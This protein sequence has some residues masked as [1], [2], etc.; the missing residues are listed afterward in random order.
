MW[1]TSYAPPRTYARRSETP[2]AFYVVGSFALMMMLA[3]VMSVFGSVVMLS[4]LDEVDDDP[5]APLVESPAPA[6][7]VPR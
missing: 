7:S 1:S 6:A 2:A 3:A 5:D 4:V